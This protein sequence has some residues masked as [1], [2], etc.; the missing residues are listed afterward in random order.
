MG[1]EVF[2]EPG[3]TYSWREFIKKKPNFSIALDGIVGGPT[4]RDLKGPYVNFDHHA[5]VDRTATRCT[6]EQVHIE[7]NL[8][9]FKT[10]RKDGMPEVNIFIND[11]DEDVCL[12]V[13]LLKNF[14]RVE[15][16]AEPLINKLV[17]LEDR[18]DAT[19]GAYPFGS[20]TSRREMAWIFEPYQSARYEGRLRSATVDELK[21]IIENVCNRITDYTLGKGQ[22]LPILGSFERIGG[23]EGWVL[24]KESGAAARMAMYASGIDS[25]VTYLGPRSQI[26]PCGHDYVIGKRSVWIPFPLEK[27]IKALNKADKFSSK[28]N[29]WGGSNTIGGSPRLTGS[30]LK[31]EEVQEIINANL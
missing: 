7:I 26:E 28:I 19:A 1:I 27:I 14:E 3:V 6:S 18:L 4:K 21:L 31:P 5:K 22:E 25:F 11:V 24:T 8:G 13:W 12:A 30:A 20:I 29:K 16:H 10:F 2:L 17:Y 23:G 9:L 15:N